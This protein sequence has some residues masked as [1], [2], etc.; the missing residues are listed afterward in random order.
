MANYKYSENLHQSNH[1]DFDK[2]FTPSVEAPYPGIYRCTGCKHEIAIAGGHKLPP[3][4]HH[5]HTNASIPIRWQLMVC[6][7]KYS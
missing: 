1:G 3:Q 4:N 5:Q 7:T 6:P 2:I